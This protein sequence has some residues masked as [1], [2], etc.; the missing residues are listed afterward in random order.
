MAQ[1]VLIDRQ[2]IKAAQLQGYTP[3]TLAP[4]M[5]RL[6]LQSFAL[7]TNNITYAATG[8][9]L[10]YWQFFPSDIAGQ[11]IVPVW[12]VAQV[13]ESKAPDL[14]PG[15]QVYGFFPMAETLDIAAKA[16]APG[17]FQDMAPHRQG[18]A[19]V[20]N[21]YTVVTGKDTHASDLRSLLQPLLATSYLLCDWLADNAWFGAVQMIIGSASSKT[22]LGLCKYLAEIPD[23]PFQIIGLT[24]AG[25]AEF[26]SRAAGCDRVIT[27][28]ALQQIAQK[29]SVYI[30]M[31]GN[32]AVKS[33]LHQHL[34]DQLQHSAA[35]G[36]S[37]WDKFAP[38]ADLPGPKPQF[39]FAPAQI[40]KRR[41]EWGAGVIEG[42][43][44]RAWKR[45]AAEAATWLEVVEHTG[46]GQ[47]VP[48][49]QRL[50][51]GQVPPNEG[52]IIRA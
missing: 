13:V 39:F 48:L 37:H 4:G 45:L 17:V 22:G 42:E 41:A 7:T 29:P 21:S 8:D 50:A 36:T 46:L 24:S 19:L 11:G 23:R 9:I 18:L 38:L 30:D 2:N 15:T 33:A 47:S 34:G 12:G 52:H 28:D 43:I 3:G 51:A 27:Y 20:Y 6:H 5:T 16:I 40:A 14:P 10:K 1:R 26:V 49:W 44:T 31:A 35:V 25:N 32:A